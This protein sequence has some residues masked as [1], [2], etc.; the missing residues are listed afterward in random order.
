MKKSA[1]TVAVI[2]IL[3]PVP[4]VMA[5]APSSALEAC[6]EI[7]DSPARLACFDRE[8]AKSRPLAPAAA[9][10]AAVPATAVP[11]AANPAP[12]PTQVAPAA[13]TSPP[14]AATAAVAAPPAAGS[15][16]APSSPSATTSSGSTQGFASEQVATG[17]ELPQEQRVLH[18]R[19]SSQ[20]EIGSTR[21]FNLFLDNGQVWRHEDSHL[22]S[23]LRDGDAVTITKHSMGVYRLTRDGTKS[24]NWIK[25]QRVR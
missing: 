4:A 7:A 18:A 19:L 9:P 20:K 22:G 11:A 5:A 17:D 12:P 8:L 10:A 1:V 16:S 3:A 13:Q 21:T 15:A 2:A 24:K 25:V 6:G 23:Y 14:P